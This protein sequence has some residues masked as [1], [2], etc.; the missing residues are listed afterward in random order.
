MALRSGW[1]GPARRRK[2]DTLWKRNA[3]CGDISAVEFHESAMPCMIYAR[4]ACN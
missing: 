1:V 2:G 3:P 4:D